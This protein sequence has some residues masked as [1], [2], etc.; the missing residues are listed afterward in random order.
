MSVFYTSDIHF[1]DARIMQLCG[2][3]FATVAEMN[4]EI[5]CRSTAHVQDEDIVLI[6]G[7][8]ISPEHFDAG[9]LALLSGQNAIAEEGM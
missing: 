9:L 1:G 2:S 5:V 3:P 7:D 8:I 4:A 6:L